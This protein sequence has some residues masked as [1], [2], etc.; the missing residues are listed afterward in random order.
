MSGTI[1][2]PGARVGKYEIVAHIASGGMGAVYKAVDPELRRTVAM[3][4]LSAALAQN[5][6]ALER[7]RREARHVARLS[8]PHIV[9][10]HEYGY[11]DVGDLHFLVLEFVDGIDL[12]R[13][14]ARRGMVAPPEARLILM[15]VVKALDHAFAQ[16]IVHRDIKPSNILLARA[17]K[18]T[19]V[20]LTDLGLARTASDEEFRVTREGSTV[21][22][23]D[24][25]SPEQAR[26]SA[27]TDIRSDIY[28]LGCTAFHMLAGKAPF[29]QGGLGERLV[30]HLETPAPDVRQFCPAVSG[31]LQRPFS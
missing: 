5:E 17:G 3:K 14:I 28:S 27:G 9:A 7:F 8:H 15:Q 13:Y 19:V 22:T 11:D 2:E 29:A 24:Y 31:R 21:G 12:G 20:K 16:G 26:N 30:G 10:I 18:R 23:I 4:V 1:L 25:M 6:L